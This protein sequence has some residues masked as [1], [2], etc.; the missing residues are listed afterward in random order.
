MFYKL[1]ILDLFWKQ[2]F[3]YNQLNT[4]SVNYE[5]VVFLKYRPPLESLHNQQVHKQTG[6]CQRIN[7]VGYTSSHLNTEVKQHWAWI[8]LGWET[9]QGISGSAGTYPPPPPLWIEYSLFRLSLSQS[10]D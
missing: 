2:V 1:N 6:L 7:H 3:S 4:K 8:L 9:L 10:S 5:S